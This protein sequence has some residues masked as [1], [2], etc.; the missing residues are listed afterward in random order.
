MDFLKAKTNINIDTNS[1]IKSVADVKEDKIEAIENDVVSDINEEFKNSETSVEEKKDNV[2]DDKGK[3][4]VFNDLTQS[5]R[6]K[7]SSLLSK[8]DE[9]KNLREKLKNLNR[10]GVRALEK[11]KERLEFRISTEAITLDKERVLMKE[12]KSLNDE[13]KAASISSDSRRDVVKRI[14]ELDGEIEILKNELDEMKLT[15]INLREERKKRK[16]II[17]KKKEAREARA[18]RGE[19]GDRPRR[20]PEG[21]APTEEEMF[22]SLE[23]IVVINKK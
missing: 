17:K 22:V 7:R 19:R 15:L 10:T 13:I 23:D 21:R 2:V 6:D 4:N 9:I 14:K 1:E 11:K 20:R 12:V 8:I 16:Q 18:A 3:T 5:M